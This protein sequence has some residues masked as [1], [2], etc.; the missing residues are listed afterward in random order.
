MLKQ[1]C[2]R[3]LG[4]D[5]EALTQGDESQQ[6][7]GFLPERAEAMKRSWRENAQS[8]EL[9][10]LTQFNVPFFHPGGKSD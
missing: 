3:T 4:R 6:A 9:A 8:P 2:D 1:R 10:L 7:T 5:D